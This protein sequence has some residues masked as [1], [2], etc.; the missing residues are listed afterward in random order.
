MRD[1]KLFFLKMVQL[2]FGC[3]LLVDEGVCRE[4]VGDKLLRLEPQS[5]LVLG[6]LQS[7]T[8]VNDVPE[9]RTGHLEEMLTHFDLVLI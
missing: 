4:L 8:A 1:V 7:V 9:R 2:R 5:N 6:V 3:I